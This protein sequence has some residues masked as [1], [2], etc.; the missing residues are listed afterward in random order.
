MERRSQISQSL[1]PA[2][3]SYILWGMKIPDTS[4]GVRFSASYKGLISPCFGR[5]AHASTFAGRGIDE[6]TAITRNFILGDHARG[7][8]SPRTEFPMVLAH[9]EIGYSGELNGGSEFLVAKHRLRSTGKFSARVHQFLNSRSNL[10]GCTISG[11][12]HG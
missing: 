8:L 5:G 9:G 7:G 11:E 2:V 3:I 12:K 6:R 4:L 1:Y 10:Q